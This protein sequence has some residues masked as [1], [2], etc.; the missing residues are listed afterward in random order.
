MSK[1]DDES[2]S[3][4]SAE[5]R[6]AVRDE[7]EPLKTFL[8]SVHSSHMQNS[9]DESPASRGHNEFD[10]IFSLGQKLERYKS[11]I[12]SVFLVTQLYGYA[13]LYCRKLDSTLGGVLA[14]QFSEYGSESDHVSE[15]SANVSKNDFEL[16]DDFLENSQNATASDD[17]LESFL[18][19]GTVFAGRHL[20]S[21]FLCPILLISWHELISSSHFVSILQ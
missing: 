11:R 1:R 15:N 17:D 6:T 19:K 20:R 8:D 21:R 2:V 3:S 5:I 10:K 14:H 9:F 4:E 16:S 18:K 12:I 13:L 7:L